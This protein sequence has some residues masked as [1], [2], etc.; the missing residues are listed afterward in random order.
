WLPDL[1]VVFDLYNEPHDIAWSCWRDGGR[2]GNGWTAAGVNQLVAAVP[3]TGA[4]NVVKAGG[5]ARAGDL[6]LGL[7]TRLRRRDQGAPPPRQLTRGAGA[8]CRTTVPGLVPASW[9]HLSR[10]RV[11]IPA[12]HAPRGNGASHESAGSGWIALASPH[13]RGSVDRSVLL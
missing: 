1:G 3:G 4:K 13:A 2:P 10:R 12:R 9:I 11:L 7:P 6:S 8:R 5:P